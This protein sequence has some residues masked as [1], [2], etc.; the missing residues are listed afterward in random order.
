MADL[1]GDEPPIGVGA[2]PVWEC[3]YTLV[4]KLLDNLWVSSLI[5]VHF[6]DL[7]MNDILSE[8]GNYSKTDIICCQAMLVIE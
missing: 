4:E 1:Q 7:G 5:F 8:F 2:S 6:T 3:T